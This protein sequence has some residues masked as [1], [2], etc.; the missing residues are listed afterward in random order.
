MAD[1]VYRDYPEANLRGLENALRSMDNQ[2]AS[3]S[4]EVN[5]LNHQVGS[6]DQSFSSFL[7]EF[8]AF[9][10]QDL[11]D[12]RLQEA[13]NDQVTLQQELERRFARHQEVRKYVTGIL[14]ASDVKLVRKSTMENA[15]EE[16]MISVPHYWLVP[17]LVAMAAWINDNR[18]LA[19][20]A[21]REAINR[22]DEKT[23]LL[24][25]LIC[26]RAS[27]NN[28]SLSWLQRYFKMQDPM[29]IEN[30][31]IVVL[32]AYANGLFGADA[33]GECI[34]QIGLWIAEMED[35][36]GFRET[37]VQRW[38]DAI[39]GKIVH[40]N[41][42]SFKYLKQYA[43]NWSSIQNMLNNAGLHAQMHAYLESVFESP[44]DDVK[45][46]K[47]KL[48][49]LLDSLV[50][51][52]DLDELPLRKDLQMC[53]L[54]IENQ[55][56]EQEAL[57]IFNSQK[58]IFDEKT[59]LTHLL[60][61]AAMNPELVHAS[62]A[63]QKLSMSIS[64]DWMIEAYESIHLENQLQEVSLIELDI[65]GFK[66]STEEGENESQLCDDVKSYLHDQRDKQLAQTKQPVT[67]Y[68]WAAG[69]VGVFLISLFGGLALIG[70][71]A[72]GLGAAKMYLGRRKY[73]RTLEQIKEKYENNVKSYQELIKAI[74]AEVIDL[75]RLTRQ[76]DSAYPP[77]KDY[78]KHIEPQQFIQSFGERQIYT[79]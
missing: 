60:T 40:Q 66:C 38:Q 33:R 62:L 8:K 47:E 31:M 32:D 4:V 39:R 70:L 7:S 57:R 56:D 34:Q 2:I 24:F 11:K 59:D 13:L 21:L 17:A 29:D 3:L 79:A 43:T 30:K 9:V 51:N 36:V 23:S 77:L 42:D 18:E 61:N 10:V 76:L 71:I 69:G 5:S 14:Q 25:C 28:A 35:V 22:D 15:T 16:L 64:K 75:R 73:L 12:K 20:K 65:D 37:Q 50:S 48:D 41:T 72:L 6:L 44:P 45:D 46:L 49:Q 78:M 67:D 27:R 19:Q 58:S 63:T 26:R 52:Y 54:I 68:Y 74:C 53:N 55:G 1:V